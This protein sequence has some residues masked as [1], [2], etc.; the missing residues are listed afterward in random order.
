M[1][2]LVLQTPPFIAKQP[3]LFRLIDRGLRVQII[4]K[5]FRRQPRDFF[6]FARFFK[7]ARRAPP[8]DFYIRFEKSVLDYA[9]TV[10]KHAAGQLRAGKF[11]FSH[12][13]SS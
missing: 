9:N 5:P 7:Q 8:D 12:T 11:Q 6:E 10:I 13:K 4:S 2:Q 3:L 1:R